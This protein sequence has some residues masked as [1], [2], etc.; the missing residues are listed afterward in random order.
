[1]KTLKQLKEEYDSRVLSQ[2]T[3]APEELMLEGSKERVVPL[4]SQMPAMLLFRRIAYRLYPD[5]QV[6]ALYYSKA[7]NKYLS[8][9]FG[10]D[11]NLNLSES[12]VYDT[13]EDL[14]LNEGAKWEAIKGGL[15]G[16][17]HGTIRGGAIGGAIAPGPG[18]AIGAVVGGVRGAYKGAK[19]GLEKAKEQNME[20]GWSDAKYKNPE[21]GLTKAG[22]MRYRRENPGSKLQTAVTTKPSKL[23]PG[24]KAANRR[25]SFC[26][27]MGGMKKRLTSAKTARDPDSRIN[28]ALRKWNCEENFTLKLSQLREEKLNEGLKDTLVSIGKSMPGYEDKEASKTAWKKGDYLGAIKSQGKALGKAALTGVAVAGAGYLAGRTIPN[29]A[30]KAIDAV[31]SSDETKS[32]ETQSAFTAAP[33]G[34]ARQ[35]RGPKTYSSWETQRSPK[36]VQQSRL[37]AATMKGVS[38]SRQQKVQENKI[39]DIRTM[40]DEGLNTLNLSI[41]GR[42]IT[43]NSSMAKRILEVYDSVNTKNK[44]IVEGMLNE[45]MESFK[46]LLNFSIKA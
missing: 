4:P 16:A 27:R 42:E 44:K 14:D 19:R 43:L 29:L 38:S 22:V 17:I 45:D 36:S 1:M 8:V 12:S 30:K 31:S 41:N 20:E 23:K 6:V 32:K 3:Q 35:I 10:P 33:G 13:L 18:T 7:V 5:K 25:K 40:I 28:K 21:G 39:S 11:G 34:H 2:V 15:S 24:S 37:D 9:P 46:K 26:A